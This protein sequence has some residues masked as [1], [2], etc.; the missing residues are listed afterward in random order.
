ME[1]RRRVYSSRSVASAARGGEHYR[2]D[3]GTIKIVC[4]LSPEELATFHAW[5]VRFD[6]ESWDCLFEADIKAG[7]L[8]ASAEQAFRE[9]N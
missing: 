5:Y 6:A 9:H 3:W 2:S 7:K 4:Q 1:A 8:D